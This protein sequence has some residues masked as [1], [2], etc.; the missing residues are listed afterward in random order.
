M[1]VN[2]ILIAPDGRNKKVVLLSCFCYFRTLQFFNLIKDL[3]ASPRGMNW[4]ILFKNCEASLG[5][6]NPLEGLK[7]R[8]LETLT[9][10]QSKIHLSRLHGA[11][12]RSYDIPQYLEV[13]GE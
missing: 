5:E 2:T 3:G 4:R 10:M 12:L 7:L 9:F 8:H 13:V 11:F 1:S 6:L